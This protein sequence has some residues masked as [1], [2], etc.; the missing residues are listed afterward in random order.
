MNTLAKTN[1]KSH[2]SPFSAVDPNGY[3]Q[4]KCGG[5]ATNTLG[6]DCVCGIR[7][8]GTNS[9]NLIGVAYIIIT[10]HIYYHIIIYVIIIIYSPVRNSR[11]LQ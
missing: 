9:S 5:H 8:H 7:S 4:Q 1:D 10:Y 11:R 2:V 6:G 3:P